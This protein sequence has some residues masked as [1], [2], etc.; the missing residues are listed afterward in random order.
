MDG[1]RYQVKVDSTLSDEFDELT[2][3]K[4]GNV[5]SPLLFNIAFEKLIRSVQRNN[6][7]VEIDEIVLDVLRILDDINILGSILLGEDKNSVVKNTTSLINEQ[8]G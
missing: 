2:E 8:N 5:L 7:G 6:R 3:L 4:Q 1:T